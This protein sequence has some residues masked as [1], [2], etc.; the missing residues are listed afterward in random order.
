M[1]RSN[2][3]IRIRD[4]VAKGLHPESLRR[5]YHRGV[6]ERIDRGLYALPHADLS[7]HNGLALATRQIPKC[8]I[9]LVSALSFHEVGTQAPPRI[10]LAIDRRTNWPRIKYPP[11]KVFRFSDPSFSSG[12]EEHVIDGVSVR[13]YSVAKTVADCFKFR[14]KVGLDVC[15]EALRE[16][17]RNR[18]RAADEIWEFAKVCRVTRVMLPYM[19]AMP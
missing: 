5:L 7:A 16:C 15:L 4:V 19:E 12:I 10:W 11:T 6:L 18:R 2:G 8:V 13:I 14:N 1:V 9:C 3:I 17:L